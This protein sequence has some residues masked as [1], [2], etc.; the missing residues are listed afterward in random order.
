MLWINFLGLTSSF[1]N[2]EILL[3]KLL[4][5]LVSGIGT[6]LGSTTYFGC[7]SGTLDEILKEISTFKGCRRR[8]R[9]FSVILCCTIWIVF[10]MNMAFVVYVFYFTDGILDI[11]LVPIGTLIPRDSKTLTFA[12]VCYTVLHD[13]VVASRHFPVAL[14]LQLAF[15][16]HEEFGQLAREFQSA[17]EDQHVSAKTVE[18]FRFRHQSLSRSV[19]KADRFASFYNAT[20]MSVCIGVLIILLFNMIWYP[21]SDPIV[22]FMNAFWLIEVSFSLRLTA[23]G[24]ILVNH[25]VSEHYGLWT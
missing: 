18:L 12:R 7:S 24:G 14:L 16:Y 20:N 15:V 3:W 25:S 1:I 13:F 2:S 6:F 9:M 5:F 21:R 19:R 4:I 11:L 17:V 10:A 8:A 22:A 23:G